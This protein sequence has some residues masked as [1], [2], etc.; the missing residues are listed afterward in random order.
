MGGVSYLWHHWN[1]RSVQFLVFCCWLQIIRFPVGAKWRDSCCIFL[2]LRFHYGRSA[3]VS[4]VFIGCFRQVG[5]I[6]G[7]FGQKDYILSYILQCLKP[8]SEGA[9]KNIFSKQTVKIPRSQNQKWFQQG[10]PCL[11]NLLCRI[12]E[13]LQAHHAIFPS[14]H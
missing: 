13:T 6:V 1:F 7:C 2:F 11:S 12:L 10:Q 8:S 3:V 14:F 9:K 5:L 4:S